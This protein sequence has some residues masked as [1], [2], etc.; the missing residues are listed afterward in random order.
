[1]GG[2]I[3]L[4]NIK[5]TII[6]S[7]NQKELETIL[8]NEDFIPVNNNFPKKI[9][10]VIFYLRRML[11]HSG[12]YTSILRLGT[13]LEKNGFNVYYAILSSK[14][15][16]EDA[17]KCAAINLKNYQ[18]K[19]IKA[20]SISSNENDIIIATYW[21]TVF[22]IKSLKGYKTYFVQDFEPYF[23]VFGEEYL[24][25][26]KTYELG[27]HMISLGGWNKSMI[28]KNAYINGKLDI[29][30]F[31]FEP[32][33]YVL[34]KRDYQQ[35]KNKKNFTIAAFIKTDQ[36]RIPNVIQSMLVN[37]EKEFLKNGYALKVK[38]FGVDKKMKLKNG[39]NLGMLNKEELA[40]LY[41]EA[42]FGICGSM[43]NVSLVPYEML[44]KGLPLI[45]FEEG[46]YQFF[47][48]DK[49]AIITN[50]SYVNLY[51]KLIHAIN[52][53]DILELYQKN[54]LE[55]LKNLSW[56]KTGKQFVKILEGCKLHD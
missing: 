21:K 34:K 54:A 2:E 4:N 16:Q 11:P 47:F 48:P 15:N 9:N 42:D 39:E 26:L 51:S 10:R 18:G 30:D 22:Q 36:K 5:R 35:Y 13:E 12:G 3:M 38:Y 6:Q 27:F 43:T 44:A 19:I 45:E 52:N 31:P 7:K 8:A 56:E 28:E 20:D 46:T 41:E 32:S 24:L 17:M 37:L 40:N 1:M 49:T 50:F 29:I 53:P 14:Q 55:F 33:E 23:T 25:T